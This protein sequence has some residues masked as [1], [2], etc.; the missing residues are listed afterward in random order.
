MNL[1]KLQKHTRVQIDLE[2][3]DS[4]KKE[5]QMLSTYRSEYGP[6]PV[7]DVVPDQLSLDTGSSCL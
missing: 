6:I 3:N 7:S 5:S 1:R 4:L 2:K